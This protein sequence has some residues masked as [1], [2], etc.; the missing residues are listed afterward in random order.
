MTEALVTLFTSVTVLAGRPKLNEH[1]KNDAD[2]SAIFLP[3]QGERV[4]TQW[5][6]N[7]RVFIGAIDDLARTHAHGPL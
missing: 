6:T 5:W 1:V 2:C 7:E 4:K 3:R